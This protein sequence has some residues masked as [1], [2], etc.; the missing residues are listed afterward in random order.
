MLPE[1]KS[2]RRINNV[3]DDTLP[4]DIDRRLFLRTAVAGLFTG[5][6]A[7]CLGQDS[8]NTNDTNGTSDIILRQPWNATPAWAFAHIAL[9]E[10]HWND[11][12]IQPPDVRPGENS[13]DT[14]R[15]VGTG[16]EEIGYG[17][18]ASTTSGLAEGYNLQMFGTP[19]NRQILTFFYVKD[20]LNGEDDLENANVALASPFAETTW[21]VYPSV[22]G[23]DPNDV[24][25]AEFA[26][27]EVVTGL[28]ES[29]EVNAV[30]GSLQQLAVYERQL[31]LD[32]GVSPLGTHAN[33]YGYPFFVNGDW[34][35]DEGN[36]DYAVGLLEGYSKAQRWCM[37]NPS[38]TMDILVNEVNTALQS[39]EEDQLEDELKV[40]VAL[41]MGE[42]VQENG[43]GS[44]TVEKTQE[45]IDIV[46]EALIDNPD[47][48]PPGEDLVLTEIQDRAELATFDSDEWSEVE[49]YAGRW[50]EYF[51]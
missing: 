40:A 15:R 35:S 42:G 6:F 27:Q 31:D 12:G 17:D 32:F 45:T 29:G 7:G 14:A 23:V 43:L 37:L 39:Q 11:V 38:E 51:R 20:E 26:E 3:L 30:W 25:S 36:I 28:L 21:P 46:G 24:G 1:G 44:I 34:I 41:S 13:P 16:T 22:V 48:L 50:N 18:W 9:K 8:T 10:G 19:R 49:N 5:S 47:D 4:N 2:L 33:I